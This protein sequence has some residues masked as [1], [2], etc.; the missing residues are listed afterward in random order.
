MTVKSSLPLV[1]LHPL[2]NRKEEKE[3]IPNNLEVRG[4][5]EVAPS[6]PVVLG[7]GIL[8]ADNGVLGS[9]RLVEVGKLLVGEPLALVGLRVLEVKVVLLGVGL[10]ELAGGNVE[11]DLDLAG[12]TSLFN[13]LGDEVKSL[14]GGLNVGSN[15]TLVTNVTSGLTVLGLGK[16]L[17]LVVDLSTL[18]EGLREGWGG[19]TKVSILSLKT[20]NLLGT[21]IPWD[22]HE[23]LE[24]KTAASVRTTV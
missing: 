24:S 17:E 20:A 1:S 19:T 2:V 12:V 3:H 7:E 10:V 5:E 14:L 13:G 11:G 16:G 8:D 21:H 18:A 15:T 22:D 23:L 4:L 6:L 9:E